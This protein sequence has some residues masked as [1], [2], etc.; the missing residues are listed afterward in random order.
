MKCARLHGS[1]LLSTRTWK[2]N[3]NRSIHSIHAD[4]TSTSAVIEIYS[5]VVPP[6][7]STSVL[8]DQKLRALRNKEDA[9]PVVQ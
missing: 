2:F 8:D 3:P 9:A 5:V 7:D 6:V 1:A 4:S